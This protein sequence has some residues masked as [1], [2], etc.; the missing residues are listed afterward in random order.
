M[1]LW[2]PQQREWL[3]AMGHSLLVLAGDEPAEPAASLR[4]EAPT[5]PRA[6]GADVG[7][8]AAAP[9]RDPI[10]VE[11]RARVRTDPAAKLAALAAARRAGA[12]GNAVGPLGEALLRATGRQPAAAARMLRGLEIDPSALRDDP[13]AKRALWSRLRSLRRA[14]AK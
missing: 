1:T 13:A 3:Q 2:D 12:A 9:A 6:R 11:P 14:A 10:E 5:A 4:G 8:H 7:E